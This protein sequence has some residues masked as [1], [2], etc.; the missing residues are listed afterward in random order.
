LPDPE[1]E[2][3]HGS[4]K[5]ASALHAYFADVRQF[6][7]CSFCMREPCARCGG[8]G[9]VPAVRRVR[10]RIPPRVEDGSQLRVGGNGNDAG[11]GSVPGDLLVRVRVLP[12]PKDPSAVRYLAFALLVVA[13]A[14]LLIYVLR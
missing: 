11:V 12:P 5:T 3:C 6:D 2:Y 8:T 13:I 7:L 4:G 14:T 10:V 1:C 9:T